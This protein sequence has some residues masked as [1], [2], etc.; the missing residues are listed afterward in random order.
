MQRRNTFYFTLMVLLT[1]PLCSIGQCPNI[2]QIDSAS[3][4]P[5]ITPEGG[6]S[7]DTLPPAVAYNSYTSN[8]TFFIPLEMNT[9]FGN[10]TVTKLKIKKIIGLPIGLKW[11]CD[12][13]NCEY[14]PQSNPPSSQYGCVRICGTPTVSEGFYPITVIADG[15][16]EVSG[17]S[18]TREVTYNTGIRILPDTTSGGA[19]DYAPQSG[20]APLDVAFETNF[21]SNGNNGYTY[22]WDF[23]NGLQSNVE[24]PQPPV[25]NQPGTYEFTCGVTIDTSSVYSLSSITLT[26][27]GNYGGGVCDNNNGDFY[28]EINGPG[29][30]YT[31]S[32]QD[33]SNPPVTWNAGLQL[34]DTTYTLTVMESDGVTCGS[35]DNL[36]SV[37]FNGAQ[38]GTIS[39]TATG[40]YGPSTVQ[41]D[42][43]HPVIEQKDTATIHVFENPK[44][45]SVRNISGT[46]TICKGD[47]ALLSISTNAPFIDWYQNDTTILSQASGD[48]SVRV[49]DT[50]IYH[51]VVRDSNGCRNESISRFIMVEGQP[52]TPY[53]LYNNNG[54]GKINA[55]NHENW[56]VRWYLDGDTLSGLS[57]T[58]YQFEPN[59]SGVYQLEYYKRGCNAFSDI[60]FIQIDT[61]TGIAKPK[62]S[63]NINIYPNPTKGEVTIS[64]PGSLADKQTEFL[65][66]DVRGRTI[67]E[68]SLPKGEAQLRLDMAGL[69]EGMYLLQIRNADHVQTE[70]IVLQ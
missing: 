11:E 42:I 38:A 46:D 49:A 61:S 56:Y 26:S 57:D 10:A 33:D 5:S 35:D 31:S 60:N 27:A 37:D 54:N 23:G 39:L 30:S 20:C 32:T 58:A 65:L 24:S 63:Y 15:T 34:T 55:T 45:D 28:I 43:A 7:P 22:D 21:P 70:R 52:P 13:S 36:G 59:A 9:Q 12:H 64:L 16:G 4:G 62:T 2:C 41:L 51:A 67:K 3:L 44:V 69:A 48:T 14:Q 66:R 19:C 25:Y 50:G 8:V 6:I 68:R 29:I 17:I 1:L 18:R 40:N 47:S 53:F